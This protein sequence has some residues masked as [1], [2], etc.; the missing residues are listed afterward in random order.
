MEQYNKDNIEISTQIEVGRAFFPLYPFFVIENDY[1]NRGRI[2]GSFELT[3]GK[4]TSDMMSRDMISEYS[5]G[6]NVWSLVKKTFGLAPLFITGKNINDDLFLVSYRHYENNDFIYVFQVT[7]DDGWKP[8]RFTTCEGVKLTGSNVHGHKSLI[9]NV[10]PFDEKLSFRKI[11]YPVPVDV[12]VSPDEVRQSIE[13]F[14]NEVNTLMDVATPMME[15]KFQNPRCRNLLPHIDGIYRV[16][17]KLD[18]IN[19]YTYANFWSFAI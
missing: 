5:R 15:I 16:S 19:G 18:H 4:K 1:F 14:I 3:F 13:P 8:Y 11:R 17:K 9:L 6:G 2:R 12:D 10:P 7:K